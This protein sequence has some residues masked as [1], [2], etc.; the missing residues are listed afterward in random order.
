MIQKNI[1]NIKRA[2]LKVNEYAKKAP[3]KVKKA[4]ETMAL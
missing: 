2:I 4:V 1:K 3:Q